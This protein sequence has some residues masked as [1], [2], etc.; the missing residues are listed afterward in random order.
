MWKYLFYRPSKRYRSTII[1]LKKLVW[2]GLV[3]KKKKD[4]ATI[5]V[6]EHLADIMLRK[7]LNPKY[8]YLGILVVTMNIKNVSIPKALIDLGETIN[9]MNKDTM[10]KLNLQELLRHTATI[11]QSE[12][13]STI[14]LEGMLDDITV[15][16]D[17]WEYPTNFIVLRTKNKLSGYPLILGIP[18]L[19]TTDAYIICR[20]G[21]M[22][23][24]NGLSKK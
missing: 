13:S 8:R 9:V 6:V 7:V 1:L 16:V 12:N 10:L 15:C 17:S 18:W 22:T 23:I 5:N 19:A 14:Y 21:N 4:L 24:G 20:K 2:K 3:E 11:L